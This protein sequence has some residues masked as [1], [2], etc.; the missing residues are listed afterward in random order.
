MIVDDI[1]SDIEMA[2][3]PFLEAGIDI[4]EELPYQESRKSTF[5][6]RFSKKSKSGNSDRINVTHDTKFLE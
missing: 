4:P 1:E 6:M 2:K 5:Q 3:D